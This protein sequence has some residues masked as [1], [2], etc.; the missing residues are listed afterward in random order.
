MSSPTVTIFDPQGIPHD[1]P[2]EHMKDALSNG[3]TMG[4]RMSDPTGQV[5]IVPATHMKEAYANGGK[6]LPIEQ[7]ETD[8]PGFWHA[9]IPDAIGLAKAFPQSAIAAT[10][11]SNFQEA[12]PD[13]AQKA[14]GYTSIED[15]AKSMAANDQARKQ[16]GRSGVYRAIAPVGEA[17]GANVKGMEDSADEGDV[18]GVAGHAAVPIAA[19]LAPLAIEGGLRG[20]RAVVPE[21]AA[22]SAKPAIAKV[23]RAASDIVHPDLTGAVSPRLAHLQRLAGHLADALEKPDTTGVEPPPKPST[24]G[25]TYRDATR[26]NEPYAGEG[27]AEKPAATAPFY[28]DATRQNQPYA[29]EEGETPKP[30]EQAPTYRDSTKENTPYAGDERPG[31]QKYRDS[32]K[33]NVPYA[34]ENL[35]AATSKVVDTLV[36]GNDRATNLQAQAQVDFHLKQGDVA[37]AERALDSFAKQADPNYKAPARP[38]TSVTDKNANNEPT[39]NRQT[40]RQ[41]AG[42]TNDIRAKLTQRADSLEDRDISQRMNW[43]LEREGY[44][45][46]SE[47]RRE[48]IARNSTGNTKGGAIERANQLRQQLQSAPNLNQDLTDIL[49]KSVEAAQNRRGSQAKP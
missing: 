9:A 28:R 25:E 26:Q 37:G 10:G 39:Q 30:A 15:Q 7:Q 43:D 41:Y 33:E 38:A 17:L 4:V 32:T 49:Q 36:G 13:S 44:S 34:G 21:G 35:G 12:L 2:Y 11:L 40:P 27:E 20:V 5:R 16:A 23:A 8:H 3:G 6:I 24:G 47:A 46:E 48:F 31:A 29:G 19:A 45:A 18:A 1:V 14:I 42:T 22:A